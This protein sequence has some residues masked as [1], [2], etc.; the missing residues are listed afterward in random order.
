MWARQERLRSIQGVELDILDTREHRSWHLGRWRHSNLKA[1][2]EIEEGDSIIYTETP[3]AESQ[4][5]R[6]LPF[7]R[8]RSEIFLDFVRIED[9]YEGVKTIWTTSAILQRYISGPKT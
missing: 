4:Y 9:G 5:K 1:D 3:D 6:P 2:G 7:Y 8:L